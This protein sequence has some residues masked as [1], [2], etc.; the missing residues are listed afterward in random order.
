MISTSGF[1]RFKEKFKN[2]IIRQDVMED[3]EFEKSETTDE[4]L[5]TN[6]GKSPKKIIGPGIELKPVES[7]HLQSLPYSLVCQLTMTY[8]KIGS[9]GKPVQNG[10][11]GFLVGSG[12]LI[13]TAGHNLLDPEPTNLGIPKEIKVSVGGKPLSEPLKADSFKPSSKWLDKPIRGEPYDYGF[14]KLPVRFGVTFAL[15]GS[16]RENQTID[17]C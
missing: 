9:N 4:V 14:I 1:H 12:K 11:T 2:Y 17:L 6:A 10:G 7:R 8:H 16:D 3:P 13:A 5:N 15:E